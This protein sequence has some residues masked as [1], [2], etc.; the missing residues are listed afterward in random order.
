MQNEISAVMDKISVY[1]KKLSGALDAG[2]MSAEEFRDNASELVPS[3][4]ALLTEI[5]QDIIVPYKEFFGT[6]RVFCK[7][8][9]NIDFLIENVDNM[10]SSLELFLEC[11]TQIKKEYTD[12]F[13]ICTCCGSNVRYTRLPSFYSEKIGNDSKFHFETIN[14]KE[15]LCPICQATDRDRLLIYFLKKIGLQKSSEGLK[16]LQ[17]A[18]SMP[19]E[20]WL[21]ENCPHVS[22][23]S[24]DLFMKN[25]T[26]TADIQDLSMV[27]DAAYD[28][29]ICSHVLEHVKDDRKALNEMK[30][31]LKPEGMILFLVPVDLNTDIIDEEWGLSEDENWKRFGQGDHCRLYGKRSLVE[32]MKEYF[33]VNELGKDYFGEDIF[34]MGSFTETSTLYVLT[35]DKDVKLDVADHTIVDEEL[36]KNGPLVSVIMCCYNHEKYVAEAIESVINQSYQNIEFLVADDGSPDHSVDIM[37]QYSKYFKKEFYFE[38]N[39]GSRFQLLIDSATG[40]YTAIIN[41][42]DVWD[43]NKI[44][45]QVAYMEAHKEC[46]ACFT[47]CQFTDENLNPV[48]D[49]TFI[50]GNMSSYEWIHYFW[51]KGNALC[52]PSSLILTEIN[53]QIPLYGTACWQLPDFFKWVNMVQNYNIHIMNKPLTFMRQT[54]RNVSRNTKLNWC[55]HTVEEA[56]NWMWIIRNMDAAF[57]R[58]A[59]STLMY[60]P[61]ATSDVEIKCEKYF[62]LLN[63]YNVLVQNSAFCYFSEIYNDVM[64]CMF[65]K[66]KYGLKEFKEDC[67]SKGLASQLLLH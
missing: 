5:P 63:H 20:K 58:K 56:S 41:S 2:Q 1:V 25:V 37:K 30:R 4:D 22:Y 35:K 21:L 62:L 48:S 6:F 43:K 26:F 45:H 39:T 7:Q 3:L 42:D 55:R 31:I 10:A 36:C 34:H 44:A 52:N 14:N 19:V 57:F 60:N 29:V 46:G 59:F 61:E 47:W 53:K 51:T 8:C 33:Y 67:V 24:T 49:N 38:D 54:G 16:L 65:D 13:K 27:A 32:R 28:L 64:D 23:E 17:F 50:K 9:N 11:L 12:M 18:P 15:Y 66:Y 40:K